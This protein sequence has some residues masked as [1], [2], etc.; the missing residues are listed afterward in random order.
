MERKERQGKAAQVFS[1][2]AERKS[3]AKFKGKFID[4]RD[5]LIKAVEILS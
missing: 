5:Y 4:G 2:S 3:Y 1:S